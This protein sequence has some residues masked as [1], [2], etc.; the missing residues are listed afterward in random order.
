MIISYDVN[1]TIYLGFKNYTVHL[2]DL[3]VNSFMYT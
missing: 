1:Y 2:Q 3:Q